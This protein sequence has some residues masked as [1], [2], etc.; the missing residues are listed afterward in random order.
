MMVISFFYFSTLPK[1]CQSEL[2]T[3]EIFLSVSRLRFH[4]VDVI[5]IIY[6]NYVAPFL[7]HRSL[8]SDKTTTHVCCNVLETSVI[9]EIVK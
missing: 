1:K 6:H 2:N 7:V 3:L 9:L 8:Q 4:D 5:L